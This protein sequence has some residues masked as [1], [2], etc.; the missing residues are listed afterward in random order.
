MAPP[1]DDGADIDDDNEVPIS[2]E[3]KPATNTWAKLAAKPKAPS[4]QTARKQP[5]QRPAPVLDEEVP[6]V[7]DDDAAFC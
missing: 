7:W 4:V 5:P 3:P 2:D 1:N 6:D